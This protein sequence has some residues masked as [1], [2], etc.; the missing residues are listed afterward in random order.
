[1]VV[2]LFLAVLLASVSRSGN[3]FV[4]LG[5]ASG[6]RLLMSSGGK[7]DEEVGLMVCVASIEKPLGLILEEREGRVGCEVIGIDPNGN[8]MASRA[9]VLIGDRILMIDD[10]ACGESDFDS[11][12]SLIG[13]SP[14]ASVEL[15]LGRRLDVVRV[16]FP[17]GAAV[18]AAPGDRLQAVAQRANWGVKYSCT[19]GSCG[20][21]EHKLRTGDGEDRYTRL[22][23]ARVPKSSP[24]IAIRKGDRFA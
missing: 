7:A 10:A 2:R 16:T 24:E 6:H 13:S 11:V 9:D 5:R 3:A 15:T 1:M 12:C 4:T 17:N 22:C 19:G 14:G 18:G 8:A 20:T 23:V 21:C